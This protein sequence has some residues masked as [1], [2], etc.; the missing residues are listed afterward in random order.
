MSRE[1][2]IPSITC[3]TVC[4]PDFHLDQANI[5]IR[6]IIGYPSSF[7]EYRRKVAGPA[8]PAICTLIFVT[9]LFISMSDKLTKR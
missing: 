4:E 1:T 9:P 7:P 8:I 2:K 5:G 6:R 3:P